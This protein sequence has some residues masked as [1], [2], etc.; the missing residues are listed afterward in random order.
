MEHTPGP[1]HSEWQYEGKGSL[2]VYGPEGQC[3]ATVRQG[4]DKHT[5]NVR[6]IAAAPE[7]LHVLKTFVHAS[8]HG[9]VSVA[10]HIEQFIV[11]IAKAE[12]R[13]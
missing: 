11:A 4:A 10:D 6:L 7:L 2:E 9:G 3:V 8:Q 5:A 1:W 13:N 12:G